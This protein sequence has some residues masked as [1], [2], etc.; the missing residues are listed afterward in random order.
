VRSR[1]LEAALTDFVH[2]AAEHLGADTAAGAEVPFEI[3]ARGSRLHR[4]PMYC[5]RP[6]TE[7]FIRERAETLSLLPS[8]A[9]ALGLLASVDGL[10]RYVASRGA[11][12]APAGS[13]ERAGH[14]LRALLDDVFEGQTDFELR[15]DRLTEALERVDTAATTGADQ[16][17]VVAT[18]HGLALASEEFPLASSLVLAQPG[19]LRGAPEEAL[20]QVRDV[21]H[22]LA[23]LTAEGGD[24]DGAVARARAVLRELLRALRLFGDGRVTLGALAWSRV[25]S[26]SWRPLALGTGGRPHGLLVVTAEQEDELRAFCNLV[27]RRAPHGNHLAWALDRF[28]MGCERASDHEALSDYLL[29]LRAL[30]EPEGPASGLLPDRLAALCALPDRRE[31]LAQRVAHAVTLERTVISGAAPAQASADALVRA[32]GD[33]LRA[34]L[35]DVICG[36]LDPDLDR[37]ADELL[38]LDEEDDEDQTEPVGAEVAVAARAGEPEE[39][40]HA[41]GADPPARWA[42]PSPPSP[43]WMD[44]EQQEGM[45]PF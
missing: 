6:L 37:V 23:V 41:D 26:G 16:V 14:A 28:E 32:I 11:D 12:P 4:T 38:L 2:E 13:H 39:L 34:L 44:A 24:A 17:T 10:D 19:A 42:P 5:Y 43:Y 3:V 30:L 21:P 40:R 18:I 36:H 7:T 33:H 9:V 35:R 20:A 27:S 31:A 1:Q 25:A 29:A 22:L 45:L 15:P 8:Y